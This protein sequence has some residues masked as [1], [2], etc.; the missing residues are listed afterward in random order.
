MDK[1]AEECNLTR[2][3][4]DKIC[5]RLTESEHRVSATEDLTAHHTQQIAELELTVKALVTKSD[6]AENHLRRNNVRVFDLPEGAEG[7]RPTNFTE[8]FF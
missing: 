6:E 3:D 4:L 2:A 8:N 5:G 7:D 1:L